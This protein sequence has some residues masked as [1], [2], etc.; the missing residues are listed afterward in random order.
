MA[1]PRVRITHDEVGSLPEGLQRKPNGYYYLRRRVPKDLVAVLGYAEYSKALDT[2]DPKAARRMLPQRLADLLEEFDAVRRGTAPSSLPLLSKKYSALPSSGGRALPQAPPAPSAVPLAAHTISDAEFEHILEM[3][4]ESKYQAQLDFRQQHEWEQLEEAVEAV[5][6]KPPD[7][8]TEAE[9]AIQM[10]YLERAEYRQLYEVKSLS[11]IQSNIASTPAA[12]AVPPST[13]VNDGASR[14]TSFDDLVDRWQVERGAAPKTVDAHRAVARW[15]CERVGPIQVEAVTKR[16]VLAFKDKLLQEGQRPSNIKVKLSRLRTLLNYAADNDIIAD[17]PAAAVKIVVPD[18]D[19]EDR[20]PFDLPAL[21]NLFASSVYSNDARPV[22]GRGEAAYWLPVLALFT[23][24]R[25]EELG[26]LRPGDVTMESYPDGDDTDQAAWFIRVTEDLRDGL[27]LKTA[28]SRRLIPVHPVLEALG[29][30]KFVS[31]AQALGHKRLFPDLRPDKYGRLTAKWGEWFGSYK[32]VEAGIVD[33]H[34][35]F[36][37]FRHTFKDHGRGRMS[38]GVQRQ[39]MGHAA[40]DVA[41][42]YGSGY[43]LWQL[44]EGMRQYKVPGLKLPPPPPRYR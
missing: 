10:L 14:T 34:M 5:V 41:D 15:F 31:E 44:V 29:F 16:H 37:S 8:M 26:Q 33:K 30:I 35:V 4:E 39:I 36:H 12:E 3:Q 38:E 7:E 17:N 19:R 18:A 40:R 28:S 43:P 1:D 23:G 22:Q 6:R 20:K 11:E 21:R 9:R 24:A 25:L 42:T 2:N 27:R 13:I 32:R